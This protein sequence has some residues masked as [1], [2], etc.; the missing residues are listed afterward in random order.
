QGVHQYAELF[1]GDPADQRQVGGPMEA[2]SA[3]LRG[4]VADPHA[5]HRAL[6]LRTVRLADRVLRRTHRTA[7][8]RRQSSCAPVGRES[9]SCRA[10]YRTETTPAVRPAAGCAAPL[11]PAA[12]QSAARRI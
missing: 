4:G 2:L 5:L 11:R 6:G 3:A 7:P 10:T 9:R 1:A 12:S 8:R